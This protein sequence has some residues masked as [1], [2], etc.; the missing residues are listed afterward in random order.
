MTLLHRA[1][2]LGASVLAA[3]V[4]V[5]VAA[6]GATLLAGCVSAPTARKN[7]DRV[8]T[9]IVEDAQHQALG[10]A[11]PLE[12]RSPAETLRKRLLLDQALPVASPASY[13]TRAVPPS[14]HF[15]EPAYLAPGGDAVDAAPAAP[16]LA[17]AGHGPLRLSLVEALQAAARNSRTFQ[18]EKEK[19]F[20]AAL[21]LDLERDAFRGAWS[22]ALQ[23]EAVADL[24]SGSLVASLDRS[25][26]V[27]LAQRFK[28]GIQ[29]TLALGFN[30]IRLLTPGAA[31]ALGPFGDASVSVPLLRG[32]G[33]LVV[34][35][36]LTQ[37]ERDTIY[38][39]YGFE[40]FKQT[41]AVD[42]ARAYYATLE[43][44]DAVHNTAENYR[45]LIASTRR[46][47]RLADAGRLPEIQVDQT[48]QEELR[49]RELWIIAQQAHAQS[50]DA[51]RL[52]LGLP[53]DAA[54]Q[55]DP[56]ELDKLIAASVQL[57]APEEKP[58]AAAGPE[59]ADAQV[60]LPPPD[61]DHVGPLELN[62]RRALR[63]AL[64]RRLDLRIAIGRVDDAQ[65]KTAVAADG[66]LPDLTLLG[67]ASLGGRV[68]VGGA[69]GADGTL[70]PDRGV[71]TA[72][73]TFDPA[74][75]RVREGR[76]YRA[77]LVDLE[78][79]AR[80]AQEVED[81]VKAGIRDTLRT[82]LTAREDF[83]IQERA[84]E[85]ARRR[86][87]STNLFLQAGR[88]EVRDLLEAQDSLVSAENARTAAAV[89]YRVAELEMERDLGVLA[90]GVDG[91]RGDLD[92][93]RRTVSE[94]SEFGS[95]EKRLCGLSD[96]ESLWFRRLRIWIRFQEVHR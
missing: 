29:V 71:Y 15:P 74:L 18:T 17:R 59:V 39:V 2:P 91:V 55:A 45:R 64:D 9:R 22:A 38:A 23:S 41:F 79:A 63:I 85:L 44:L 26:E 19:V 88:A 51:L 12:V 16:W 65:R 30:L 52:V 35:E 21:N 20:I 53:P 37:S 69:D 72:A 73:V 82:L 31:S 3:P 25:T 95:A 1:A 6:A 33:A 57:R 84:L 70:R 42:V 40:R 54:V 76:D 61:R 78:R 68:G 81:Q 80:A 36:P 32:A 94:G 86:V 56:G 50:E 47:R 28:N 67:T 62:E 96:F 13:G 8:A 14:P 11:E 83:R 66:L 92:V 24:T 89:R 77:S 34:T 58:A 48:L 46:A 75:K 43:R 49:A 27:S 60:E 4:A 10:R 7:A 93:P 87:E 90:I 5:A